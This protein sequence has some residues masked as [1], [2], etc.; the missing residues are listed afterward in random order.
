MKNLYIFD[1]DGVLTDR[2]MPIE[3]KFKNWFMGWAQGT[4]VEICYVTGSNREKTEQQIGKDMLD[5]APLS[6]HCLGNSIWINGTE[7]V[8]NEFTFTEDE[9]NWLENEIL[10][11]P[12]NLKTGN[13]IEVRKGSINFSIV[14]R[15][16][17]YEQRQLY[18]KY[19][20]E[21]NE[22]VDILERFIN[23][24]THFDAFIG[25]DISIDICVKGGHKGFAL[26]FLNPFA[27]ENLYSFGDKYTKYGV[28]FPF[29]QYTAKNYKF[30]PIDDGY[31]QTFA[32]IKKL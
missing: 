12:F 22:R 21:K 6:F 30:F 13:H 14:G 7:T 31:Q 16:A 11:S 24:F 10:K 2:S 32:T 5:L 18:K 1:V 23:K 15:N 9:R 25:G 3:P 17:S 29:T 19:D 26:S 4:D 8:I 27:Y 20:E 28:D